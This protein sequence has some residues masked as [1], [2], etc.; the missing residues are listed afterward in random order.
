MIAFIAP[1]L[2]LAAAQASATPTPA[3]LTPQ[4]ADARCVAA[5]GIMGSDAKEEVQRASQLG[6]LYFYGKLVGR[7][8]GID[9]KAA[10]LAAATAVA[11]NPKPEVLRCGA[12]LQKSGEA[13]Q[14]VGASIGAAPAAPA[15]A[16]AAKPGP[17][18]TR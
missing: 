3:P 10:M 12:E 15:P 4:A 1:V 5:F 16:P 6:A 13:M 14:A 8:P 18:P 2:A 7:D 11:P 9:L 17:K